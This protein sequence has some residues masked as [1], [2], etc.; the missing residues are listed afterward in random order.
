MKTRPQMFNVETQPARLHLH[1]LAGV[2]PMDFSHLSNGIKLLGGRE[3]TRM[4][5]FDV[6]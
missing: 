1:P 2:L 4:L 6:V 5:S 3:A